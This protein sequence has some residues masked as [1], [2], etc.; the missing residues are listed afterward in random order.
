MQE[1]LA[2]TYAEYS[3]DYKADQSLAR[4]YLKGMWRGTFEMP[5]DSRN[6]SNTTPSSAPLYENCTV[7]PL[8]RLTRKVLG[9]RLPPVQQHIHQ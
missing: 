7:G 5:W 2:V 8:S 3:T 9:E 1:G 6:R 4:S